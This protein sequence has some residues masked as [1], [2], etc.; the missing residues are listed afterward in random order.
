MKRLGLVVGV[1][2]DKNCQSPEEASNW[3]LKYFLKLWC[4]PAFKVSE[5]DVAVSLKRCL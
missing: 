4:L 3:D 1:V 2:C 5:E